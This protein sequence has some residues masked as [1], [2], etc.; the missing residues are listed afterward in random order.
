LSGFR[1]WRE[2]ENEGRGRVRETGTERERERRDRETETETE[3]ETERERQR[4]RETER[5][6]DC[7]CVCVV[8]RARNLCY[9]CSPFFHHLSATTAYKHNSRPRAHSPLLLT[10]TLHAPILPSLDHTIKNK[11]RN[12]SGA[13]IRKSMKKADQK[14]T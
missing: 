12:R 14:H 8:A 6:R 13:P 11:I 3:T 9:A 2:G 1:G 10:L 7:V 4:E 5:E